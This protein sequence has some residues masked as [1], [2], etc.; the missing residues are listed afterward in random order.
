MSA[1]WLDGLLHHPDQPQAM[2]VFDGQK[3]VV[4]GNSSGM[5]RDTAVIIG[6]EQDRVED[7]VNTLAPAAGQPPNSALMRNCRSCM[8]AS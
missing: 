2:P 5:G 1:N 4:V 7:T 3:P 8:A 6:Q